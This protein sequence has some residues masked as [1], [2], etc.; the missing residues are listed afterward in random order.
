MKM[1]F[2]EDGDR[3]FPTDGRAMTFTLPANDTIALN[4]TGSFETTFSISLGRKDALENNK[5]IYH[6]QGGDGDRPYIAL[7]WN[8]ADRKGMNA[9]NASAVANFTLNFDI[10]IP[11]KPDNDG[12]IAFTQVIG[13]ELVEDPNYNVEVNKTG[14]FA[15]DTDDRTILC[16]TVDVAATEG[17]AKDMMLTDEMG[18]ALTFLNTPG[19][20]SV[21]DITSDNKDRSGHEVAV[22]YQKRIKEDEDEEPLW[23]NLPEG[24]NPYDPNNIQIVSQEARGLTLK[25]KTLKEGHRALI[26]YDARVNYVKLGGKDNVG[27]TSRNT[28]TA[29]KENGDF[30]D[31]AFHH[32]TADTIFLLMS[33]A[34]STPE[35]YDASGV[36]L[37]DNP[38]TTNINE[39][40][41]WDKQYIKW[42]LTYNDERHID[43][44][45]A[46]LHD[47]M[48]DGA[49][50]AAKYATDKPF[51][52]QATSD[53][54][55]FIDILNCTG[56]PTPW[57]SDDG[58]TVVDYFPR[59]KGYDVYNTKLPPGTEKED[60]DGFVDLLESRLGA[61]TEQELEDL[62]S[63]FGYKAPHTG[64]LPTGDDLP[65][66]PIA[67]AAAGLLALAAAVVL[68]RKRRV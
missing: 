27:T 45:G 67:F 52:V 5:V 38:N 36:R 46:T 40:T 51:T 44:E 31:D 53:G 49:R 20:E 8:T 57:G 24:E 61:M 14:A 21:T 10:T 58:I 30:L 33:K 26:N 62:M 18:A 29:T 50:E 47:E 66:W 11:K 1:T 34:F 23:V 32:L 55:N 68:G 41:G 48:W 12:R 43:V 13:V 56:T 4:L 15:D 65:L 35:Y 19:Q 54:E 59:Y 22:T 16:Y 63:L 28:V 2:K 3:Q 37:T 17:D 6:A 64:L 39:L 7:Q 42:T 60:Y 9:L 25:V